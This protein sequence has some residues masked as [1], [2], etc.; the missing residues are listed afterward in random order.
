MIAEGLLE[1]LRRHGAGRYLAAAA[2]VLL[3]LL[4]RLVLDPLLQD[5]APFILFIPAVLVATVLGGRGPGLAAI[6]ASTLLGVLLLVAPRGELR[7]ENAKALANVAIF[8]AIGVGIVLLTHRMRVAEAA[9]RQVEERYRNLVDAVEDYAMFSLDPEG[10]VSSWNRGAGRLTGWKGPEVLGRHVSVLLPESDDA[11][12][13]VEEMLAEVCRSGRHEEDLQHRRKDGTTFTAHVVTTRLSD[14]KGRPLGFAQVI[15]DITERRASEAALRDS[16]ARLRL[17]LMAAGAGAFE[18]HADTGHTAWSDEYYELL[19]LAP[20]EVQAGTSTWLAAVHPADRARAE[21]ELL[22]AVAAG[23]GGFAIEFRIQHP[24]RGVRWLLGTGRLAYAPDGSLRQIAG[25]NIDVTRRREAEQALRARDRELRTVVD[26]A[27]DP[28][29]AKDRQGRFIF[30][31]RRTAVV[32]G[33]ASADAVPGTCDR[34]YMPEP[35]AARI[36]AVDQQVMAQGGTVVAQESVPADGGMRIYVSAKSP[37]LGEAGE[38]IGLVGV[39]RDV[40]EQVEAEAEIRRL[41]EGLERRVEERTQELAETVA[42]LDAFAY[43]VSHDLRAPLRAMEGFA[44]I[45]VEDFAG[46]LGPDGRR[47]ADRISAAARRMDDLIGDLL[48]YSRLS[49]AEVNLRRVS[50]DAVLDTAIADA[51]A[52]LG[53]SGAELRV[54]RPLPDVLGSSAILRQILANLIGNAAKFVT[55]GRRPGILVHAAP[56]GE[57]SP[58]RRI[59]LMVEDNGIGLAPE[60]RERIFRVFE[61]LHADAAYPGTGIGLAIVRRGAERLGGTAGVEPRPDGAPGSVFWIE[62]NLVPAEEPKP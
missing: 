42:Q 25:L 38:V 21:R 8:A 5:R 45:L 57:S 61:R 17:A 12:R 23:E 29:Y 39:S 28:I 44:A 22:D 37:L 27:V 15:R 36:E 35:E 56:V 43:T 1:P 62:L 46:H 49:R 47:Y 34:D 31:N 60:H 13:R 30:V 53:A 14:G 10:R 52:T 3:A 11:A 6:V 9:H 24:A 51:G 4:L 2:V 19:G 33:A 32:L 48:E 59:R 7:A 41:N 54:E 16:E 26:T 58:A 55:P 18:W 40:T 20:G 50:L